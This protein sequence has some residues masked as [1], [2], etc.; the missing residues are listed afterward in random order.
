M[1]IRDLRKFGFN[2]ALFPGEDM[3]PEE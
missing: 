3:P 2:A 1:R